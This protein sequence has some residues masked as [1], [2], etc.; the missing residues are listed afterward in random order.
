[1]KFLAGFI[2]CFAMTCVVMVPDEFLMAAQSNGALVYPL[3]TKGEQVDDYHGVKVADPL[4]AGW[5]TRTRR[6]RT[7]GSR[8]R[9]K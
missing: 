2:F 7:T 3:A 4:I 6:R 5:R 1:M 9:T 8:P